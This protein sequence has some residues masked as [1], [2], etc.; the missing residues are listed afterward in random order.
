MDGGRKR[1]VGEDY[2]GGVISPF[3]SFRGRKRE[4]EK[5]RSMPLHRNAA[6]CYSTSF[7]PADEK[8]RGEG[9]GFVYAKRRAAI[10]VGARWVSWKSR[11]RR[12]PM[13]E[14]RSNHPRDQQG[15]DIDFHPFTSCTALFFF[16][17]SFSSFSSSF[18]FSYSMNEPRTRWGNSLYRVEVGVGNVCRRLI[19]RHRSLGRVRSC[20]CYAIDWKMPCSSDRGFP[21]MLQG[22]SVLFSPR[23]VS[24]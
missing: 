17:F 21:E 19:K 13:T 18:F 4:K 24:G 2:A 9:I 8:F 14:Q 10:Q 7:L 20:F 3:S 15:A 5:V 12:I 22:H 1:E 23:S 6:T 16:S 11:R